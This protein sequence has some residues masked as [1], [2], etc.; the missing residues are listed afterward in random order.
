MLLQFRP[1][2]FSFL[3]TN[4]FFNHSRSQACYL[5]TYFYFILVLWI[6]QLNITLQVSEQIPSEFEHRKNLLEVELGDRG[7]VI[8]SIDVFNKSN[9]C[10]VFDVSVCYLVIIKHST[11]KLQDHTRLRNKH[12]KVLQFSCC[13]Q[14][15]LLPFK[16][17]WCIPKCNT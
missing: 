10:I 12:Y 11:V 3:D 17:H 5:M 15:V 2:L 9:K 1:V 14:I 7:P 16:N 4:T 13:I 6:N 8:E